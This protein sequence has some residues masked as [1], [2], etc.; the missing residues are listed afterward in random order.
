MSLIAPFPMPTSRLDSAGLMSRF[1]KDSLKARPA[2]PA[3]FAPWRRE[4]IFLQNCGIHAAL[5]S[6]RHASTRVLV[7]TQ[8]AVLYLCVDSVQPLFR[9]LGLLL[10]SRGLRP[11][12]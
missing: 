4:R 7:L 2:S 1:V 5:S 9:A 10:I 8:K 3:P 6:L 12:R 11:P